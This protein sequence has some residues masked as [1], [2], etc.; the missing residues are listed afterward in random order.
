MVVNVVFVVY[1][2]S[3]RDTFMVLDNLSV[4]LG[5]LA[6]HSSAGKSINEEAVLEVILNQHLV[7]LHGISSKVLAA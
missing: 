4:L 6:D 3:N 7:V 5:V 2:D 1:I